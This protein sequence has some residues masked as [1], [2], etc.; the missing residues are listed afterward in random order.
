MAQS[1]QK[2]VTNIAELNKV[3]ADAK[4]KLLLNVLHEPGAVFLVINSES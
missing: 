2:K 3:M 1:I 4:H